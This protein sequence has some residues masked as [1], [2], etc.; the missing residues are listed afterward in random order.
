MGSANSAPESLL[1]PSIGQLSIHQESNSTA[2]LSGQ[3]LR[4]NAAAVTVNLRWGD[5]DRG[6]DIEPTISWD[7]EI[8]V[9]TNLQTGAFSATVQLPDINKIYYFRAVASNNA[10]K[11]VSNSVAADSF[12]RVQSTLVIFPLCPR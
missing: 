9:W 8:E 11:E 6:T 5:E 10:G 3:I 12:Q 4:N 2:T 1:P 7:Y